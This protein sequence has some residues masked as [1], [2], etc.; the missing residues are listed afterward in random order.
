MKKAKKLLFASIIAG[1]LICLSTSN[2]VE[3]NPTLD[4]KFP[5][6][7]ENASISDV[8]FKVTTP[9]PDTSTLPSL[10]QTPSPTNEATPTNSHTSNTTDPTQPVHDNFLANN[11][12]AIVT[13]GGILTLVAVYLVATRLKKEA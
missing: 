1:V 5:T 3:A 9:K 12:G 4:Y 8:D 7:T 11:A 2:I 6:S 10:T 13:V